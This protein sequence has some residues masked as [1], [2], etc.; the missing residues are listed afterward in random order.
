ME[1]DKSESILSGS[2]FSQKSDLIFSEYISH[3]EYTE[4][5]LNKHIVLYKTDKFLLYKLIEFEIKENQV[6]FCHNL[7]LRDLKK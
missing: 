4:K 3:A 5:K 1:L 6:I 2:N 7:V